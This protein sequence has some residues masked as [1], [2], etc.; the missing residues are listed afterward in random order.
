MLYALIGQEKTTRFTG[1]N[2]YNLR[3]CTA[4]LLLNDFLLWYNVTKIGGDSYE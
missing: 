4:Y 3:F 2:Y 1:G